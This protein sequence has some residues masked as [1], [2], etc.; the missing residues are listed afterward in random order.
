MPK[1]AMPM[2]VLLILTVGPA[3]LIGATLWMANSLVPACTITEIERLPAPDGQF[4]LVT[5]SREC[6]T[7]TAPNSQAA[8]VPPGEEVPYDAAA[9][10]STDATAALDPRWTGDGVIELA[11]PPR[12]TVFRQDNAVAGVAVRYR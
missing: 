11:I 12:A 1:L 7:T 5:F 8:L 2:P 9:F 3:V 6:G 4:D 10:F